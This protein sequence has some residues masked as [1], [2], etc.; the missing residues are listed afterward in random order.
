MRMWRGCAGVL[1]GA[2]VASGAAGCDLREVVVT[3]AADVVVAEVVLEAGAQRQHALLHRTR[4][5][6]GGLHDVPGAVVTVRAADGSTL[7][8][9]ATMLDDCIDSTA[10]ERRGTCYRSAERPDFVEAGGAYELE[11]LLTEGGSLSGIV[12]VPG[13]FV[14]LRPLAESCRL[15]PESQ[16]ELAWSRAPAAWAYVAEASFT[17]LRAALA[18]R[19]ITVPNEPLRLTGLSISAS[20]TTM[21]FPAGLGVFG[22]FD[23]DLTAVLVALQTG[24]PSGTV[25]ELTVAAVDHNYVNWVRG[26]SF[27]PSGRPRIPSVTGVGTGVFGAVAVQRAQIRVQTTSTSGLADC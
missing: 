20:D 5:G 21:T 10:V 9:E 2:V 13:P 15:Q 19:G 18:A 12:L 11:I 4:P 22:R 7:A 17:G 27:N 3:E 16:L 1:A 24:L 6:S 23:P 25:A 8:F 26:G 14:L